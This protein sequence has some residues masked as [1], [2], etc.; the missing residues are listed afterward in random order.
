MKLGTPSQTLLSAP[1]QL[2]LTVGNWSLSCN[3]EKEVSIHNSDGQQTTVLREDL[4]GFVFESN[5]GTKHTFSAETSLGPEFVAGWTGKR[6]RKFV[7]KVEAQKQKIRNLALE[8]QEK[9]FWAAHAMPRE[10]VTKLE[11]IVTQLN[12]ACLS[13]ENQTRVCVINS[14][15]VEKYQFPNLDVVKFNS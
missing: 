13:Q 14:N 6:G 1:G 12:S 10:V 3:K 9:Y 8:I 15:C 11:E 7:S 4:A 5:R 2:K